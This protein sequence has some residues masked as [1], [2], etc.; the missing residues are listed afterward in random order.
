M[1]QARLAVY[2]PP[3]GTLLPYL[4]VV[5]HEDGA[6]QAVG[7]NTEEEAQR[8]IHDAAIRLANFAN[9]AKPDLDPNA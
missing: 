2:D 7:F 6:V 3:P 9:E 4:G 5:I 1:A 8:F